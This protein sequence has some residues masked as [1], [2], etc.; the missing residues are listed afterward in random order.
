MKKNTA[1][2]TSNA[3]F[4]LLGLNLKPIDCGEK[5]DKTNSA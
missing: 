1:F 3:V 4:N 5:G 2:Q